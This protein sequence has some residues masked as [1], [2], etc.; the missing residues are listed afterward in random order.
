MAEALVRAGVN[1]VLREWEELF[2]V[3]HSVLTLPEARM[4][5]QELAAF[6]KTHISQD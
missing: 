2:H 4:A 6:I 3:F 5:N 1:C